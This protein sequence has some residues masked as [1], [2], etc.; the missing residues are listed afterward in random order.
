MLGTGTNTG[1]NTGTGWDG[2]VTGF[3]GVFLFWAD[4]V[5]VGLNFGII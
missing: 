1:T 4:D 2:S 5:S 3:G